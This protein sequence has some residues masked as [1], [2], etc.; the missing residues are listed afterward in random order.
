MSELMMYAIW[1]APGFWAAKVASD[2]NRNGALWAFLALILGPLAILLVY[3]LP[4]QR[5]EDNSLTTTSL[6][7]LSSQMAVAYQCPKCHTVVELTMK[8]C[9]GCGGQFKAADSPGMPITFA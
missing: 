4:R 2:R 7:T 3:A 1:I 8:Y 5:T 9:P 6:S